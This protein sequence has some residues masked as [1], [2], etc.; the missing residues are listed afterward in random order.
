VV[1]VV[2]GPVLRLVDSAGY[3]TK[4]RDEVPL[5]E[6]HP[7][8]D[9]ALRGE[10]IALAGAAD[11]EREY[12]EVDRYTGDPTLT[13]PLHDQTGAVAC[14][15]GLGF[16]N[17][18]R[19]PTGLLESVPDMAA[20]WS[21]LYQRAR[22]ANAERHAAQREHAIA[23]S[24]Q[25]AMLGRPDDIV[26]AEWS[27]AYKPADGTL[28]VG[29][30]WY[31][32]ID[33]GDDCIG[34][35]VGD[36]VGHHLGA[37]AAMGQVRS[38]VRALAGTVRDPAALLN[39]VD[40]FIEHIEGAQ[41]ATIVYAVL[42]GRSGRLSYSCAG[43]LPPLLVS[44]DGSRQFLLDGRNVPLGGFVV[45]PRTSAQ[46]TMTPDQTLVLYSDGLIERRG[47]SVE[48]GM[49]RL[50]TAAATLAPR[51]DVPAL[52]SRLVADLLSGVEQR[53][54]VAVL[55]VRPIPNEIHIS[56]PADPATL[57]PTRLLLRSWLRTL[58]ASSDE[59]DELVLSAGEAL[60]NAIEHAAP[61]AVDAEVFLDAVVHEEV[62]T[63]TIRDRGQWRPPTANNPER[64]RGI[65]IMRA[66]NDVDIVTGRAG[67][68]VELR[69]KLRKAP[70]RA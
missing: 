28:E 18:S 60:T 61:V 41:C 26:H 38:A 68:T 31:D 56:R 67:T 47:E 20:H 15:I 22:A 33:L 40:G 51:L 35:V 70:V 11:W 32:L 7:P 29:G 65:D 14:V 49:E 52:C 30:D 36:I 43:H 58:D 9:A 54:D 46:I 59:I 3:A 5:D 69:R 17:R 12:P 62:V 27:V 37:A 23:V 8:T 48:V 2:D 24:L 39:H 45:R 4:L 42:D 66:F 34:L 16:A 50:A 1:Y 25:H 21:S 55:A 64:G 19:F 44:P 53:D 57:R 63:I 6:R 10:P 13:L